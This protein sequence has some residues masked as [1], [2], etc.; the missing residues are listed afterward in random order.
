MT[1]K[2][3]GVWTLAGTLALSAGSAQAASITVNSNT[4]ANTTTNWSNNLVFN[5]FDPSLGTLTSILL[6]L[7]GNVAGT[8]KFESLDAAPATVTMK[9]QAQI[10]LTRPDTSTLVTVLPVVTVIESVA[11]FDGTFDFGGTSGRT[12]EGLSAAASD[13]VTLTSVPDLALFTGLGTVSLATNATGQSTGSGAGN[14][15]TQFATN[16]GAFGQIQYNYLPDEEVPIPE[17]VSLVLVGTGLAG[18]A[19]RRWKQ[20]RP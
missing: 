8:A 3:L 14:L 2:S 17:P 5:Q 18:L 16:A 15:I 19:R 12:F 10:T 11:A 13:F 7:F 6:T 9:L 20:Q 1:A 4:I